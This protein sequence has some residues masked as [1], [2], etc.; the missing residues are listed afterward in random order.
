MVAE[1]P[2]RART[3]ARADPP[4]AYSPESNAVAEALVKTFKRDYVGGAGSRD[5]E[6]V[7]T[8]LDGWFANYDT[9]APH[10]RPLFRRG[11]PH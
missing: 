4:P 7:L 3:R 1:Q 9:Q 5:A 6:A 11:L 10:G 2:G 8:Q